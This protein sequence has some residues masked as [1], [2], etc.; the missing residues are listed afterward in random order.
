MDIAAL[1]SPLRESGRPEG[2]MNPGDDIFSRTRRS[3]LRASSKFSRMELEVAQC[4]L[5][6]PRWGFW[7]VVSAMR[8]EQSTRLP[9]PGDAGSKLIILRLGDFIALKGK[10]PSAADS[11]GLYGVKY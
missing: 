6:H 3:S 9:N 5:P 10:H 8:L 7:P 1:R 11:E 2:N 4:P